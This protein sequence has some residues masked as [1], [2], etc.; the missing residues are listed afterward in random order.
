MGIGATVLHKH[1]FLIK[2]NQ[3]PALICDD[4]DGLTFHH[5]GWLNVVVP[6]EHAGEAICNIL[7]QWQR[8]DLYTNI[9]SIVNQAGGAGKT[10][11]AVSLASRTAFKGYRV[12][13]IDAKK[14]TMAVALIG[15]MSFLCWHF[16][17]MLGLQI[18][19]RSKS[20]RGATTASRTHGICEF[21]PQD[22]H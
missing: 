17:N 20:Y 8:G 19:S 14:A 1:H 11:I 9:I 22:D 21:A 18:T 2:K 16:L 13:L 5:W 10:T 6:P 4:K 7:W 3:N 15:D 12:L